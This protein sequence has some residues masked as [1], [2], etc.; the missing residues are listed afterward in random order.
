MRQ[1]AFEALPPEATERF[2]HSFFR[3]EWET[4][5]QPEGI[6]TL[7]EYFKASR[8]GRGTPMGRKERKL[9]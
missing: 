2:S 5:I 6:T 7:A 3:E 1:H 4:I 8:S 9:I